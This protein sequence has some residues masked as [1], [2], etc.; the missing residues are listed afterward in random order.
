[1]SSNF[2]NNNLEIINS[3]KPTYGSG[4]EESLNNIF[5]VPNISFQKYNEPM[6][7]NSRSD[8]RSSMEMLRRR[9]SSSSH[10]DVLNSTFVR[11]VPLDPRYR[12]NR[13]IV[14]SSTSSFEINW[15]NNPSILVE[16]YRDFDVQPAP[17]IPQ[18]QIDSEPPTPE[19]EPIAFKTESD[20]IPFIDDNSPPLN[21][22]YI[23]PTMNDIIPSRAGIMIDKNHR[24]SNNIAA[25]RKTVSFDT[26]Q[27]DVSGGDDTFNN[28][29]NC[30]IT[31]K[32]KREDSFPKSKTYEYVIDVEIER[33]N[34]DEIRDTESRIKFN[35]T[36]SQ[37]QKKKEKPL[38]YASTSKSH[39][40]I[41]K[42]SIY[43]TEESQKLEQPNVKID[44]NEVA[45]DLTGINSDSTTGSSG[46]CAESPPP[47]D[48]VIDE[49]K[50]VIERADP[51]RIIW[52]RQKSLENIRFGAG[53]VQALKKFYDSFQNISSVS[54]P[55]LRD[56]LIHYKPQHDKLID[57]LTDNE[58]SCILRQLKE[59]SKYGSYATSSELPTPRE[60]STSTPN[61]SDLILH[62]NI[63][64]IDKSNLEI[65]KKFPDA[66]IIRRK[67][68]CRNS[69]SNF[70]D[71]S[72]KIS[73]NAYTYTSCPNLPH[74]PIHP[75]NFLTLKQLKSRKGRTT[76]TTTTGSVVKGY[77]KGMSWQDVE[78]MG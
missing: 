4:S 38:K 65:H 27:P 70:D 28:S 50:I 11:S 23:P 5:E 74:T 39:D 66:Y 34:C 68:Q 51:F 53:K 35:C 15:D 73:D 8:L 25:C 62:D 46:A 12:D 64:K 67:K 13:P 14:H 49:R 18:I 3:Y 77:A 78:N 6:L 30:N 43:F 9:S 56:P 72:I 48:V 69:C 40:Q 71:K 10:E 22:I 57:K 63:H 47:K 1:M 29:T 54:S 17:G 45:L 19:E 42:I 36:S 76:M 26:I 7:R 16:E 37:D 60:K 59:W 61:L 32:I 20:D 58:H 21:E 55:D 33:Q 41:D 31:N 2:N 52:P 44:P 75:S 24:R